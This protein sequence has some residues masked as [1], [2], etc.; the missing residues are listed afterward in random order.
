MGNVYKSLTE[1]I[2]DIEVVKGEDPPKV[3]L[4]WYDD[5]EHFK[6]AQQM[7]PDLLASTYQMYCTEMDAALALA[8]TKGIEVVR[9]PIDLKQFA[10]WCREQNIK[11]DGKARSEFTLNK[12]FPRKWGVKRTRGGKFILFGGGR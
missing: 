8:K 2:E 6:Q 4:T 5:E 11:M 10:E 9:C 1:A 3:A 7:M 12:A